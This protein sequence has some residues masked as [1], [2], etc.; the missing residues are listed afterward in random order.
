MGVR[1]VTSR[2]FNLYDPGENF[3]IWSAVPQ[4]KID[5]LM[6]LITTQ[7]GTV[8]PTQLTSQETAQSSRHRLQKH[9]RNSHRQ[10]GKCP[11]LKYSP[12]VT[13][14]MICSLQFN[15]LF[16]R[17]FGQ[18]FLSVICRWSKLPKCSI[19][20]RCRASDTCHWFWNG[21][22]EVVGIQSVTCSLAHFWMKNGLKS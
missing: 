12:L 8:L 19:L 1:I 21:S 3:V 20:Y 7:K 2:S 5:F 10:R 11:P 18:A 22:Q 15:G 9:C 17:Q 13:L 4:T 14:A 16:V 6:K